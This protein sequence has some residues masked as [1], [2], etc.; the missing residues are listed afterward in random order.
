MPEWDKFAAKA[1]GKAV[2]EKVNCSENPSECQGI[3][4]VPHVVFSSDSSQAVYPGERTS[5]GL[6]NFL[7]RFSS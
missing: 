7:E 1:S 5:T 4:G 3:R 6:Y 2:V